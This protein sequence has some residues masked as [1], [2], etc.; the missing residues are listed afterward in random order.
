MDFPCRLFILE[1]RKGEIKRWVITHHQSE[2]FLPENLSMDSLLD[3]FI[4]NRLQANAG[5]APRSL[6]DSTEFLHV[7][8]SPAYTRRGCTGLG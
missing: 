6:E 3:Y 7:P 2:N 5:V 1:R 4:G 8:T